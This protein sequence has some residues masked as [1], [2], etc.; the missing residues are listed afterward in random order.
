MKQFL[1]DYLS[2]RLKNP[3]VTT[4]KKGITPASFAAFLKGCLP[5]MDE[6]R[7]AV[8][9]NKV[10][11]VWTNHV[12]GEHWTLD[13]L[14]ED[15]NTGFGLIASDVSSEQESGAELV[16]KVA[17]R[18]RVAAILLYAAHCLADSG[19]K[20][21]IEQ[22]KVWLYC[23]MYE[24]ADDSQEHAIAKAL[25]DSYLSS[26]H[27][28]PIPPAATDDESED[29]YEMHYASIVDPDGGTVGLLLG[30]AVRGRADIGNVCIL[31]GWFDR[32]SQI[33]VKDN[34]VEAYFAPCLPT[35]YAFHLL[36]EKV[37]KDRLNYLAGV[38]LYSDGNDDELPPVMLQY[39]LEGDSIVLTHFLLPESVI[40]LGQATIFITSSESEE[41]VFEKDDEYERV[42]D[43]YI[44][45]KWDY[46][47]ESV[48][49]RLI[50]TIN[51]KIAQVAQTVLPRRH[52]DLLENAGVPDGKCSVSISNEYDWKVNSEG[53]IDVTV[54]FSLIRFP[55]DVVDAV[56]MSGYDD[57]KHSLDVCRKR[58]HDAYVDS[59]STTFGSTKLYNKKL[60]YYP[61][62]FNLW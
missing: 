25:L 18:G 23:I 40:K 24:R 22:A 21:D 10:E 62:D 34:Y 60:K 9:G 52:K 19:K 8:F 46:A 15:L 28:E 13:S 43:F 55:E 5:Y 47:S 33:I 17:K 41:V 39:P 1:L 54:P 30:D 37:G 45:E 35:W 29:Y 53:G 32:M 56:L 44:P 59:Y 42:W 7:Q 48:Q 12:T 6:F 57:K 26:T 61:G 27:D 31:C 51:S 14:D 58:W 38:C 49:R 36:V 2:E 16:M 3:G 4:A 11:A 50:R 20:A